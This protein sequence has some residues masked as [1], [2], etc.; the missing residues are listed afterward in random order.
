MIGDNVHISSGSVIGADAFCHYFDEKIKTFP[1]IGKAIIGDHAEIGYHTVIQRGTFSDTVVG[2]ESK[3]GNFVDIGHDVRIGSNCK[4]VSQTGIAGHASI[5]DCVTIYGQA[6]IGNY[7][8]VGDRAVVM[9]QS[10][11]TKNVQVGRKVSG[12]F[13]R[14]HGEELRRQVKINRLCEGEK[15]WEELP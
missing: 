3:I 8:T 5:G 11:V 2:E 1:G 9:A 14:E 12:S 6:G 7:V 10:R 15:K 4:I 13:A